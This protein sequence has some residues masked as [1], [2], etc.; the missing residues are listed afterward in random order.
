MPASGGAATR[1]RTLAAGRALRSALLEERGV[2]ELDGHVAFETAVVPSRPPD[3]SHATRADAF[4]ELVGAERPTLERDR[5][6]LRRQLQEPRAQGAIVLREMPFERFGEGG[7]AL[8]AA[9]ERGR[10]AARPRARGPE[11][12]AARA[13]SSALRRRRWRCC[14]NRIP[15]GEPEVAELRWLRRAAPSPDALDP[16]CRLL[17]LD[18]DLCRRCLF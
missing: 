3:R 6:R 13:G 9:I 7:V 17:P 18:L 2:K 5:R 15:G 14:G 1:I 12:G 8:L 4:D 10:R 16:P 11:G